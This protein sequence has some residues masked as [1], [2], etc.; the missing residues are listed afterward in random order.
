MRPALGAAHA[1]YRHPADIPP[2]FGDAA[3][4]GAALMIGI[5]RPLRASHLG[6]VSECSGSEL[7][8]PCQSDATRMT[9]C[10]Q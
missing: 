6:L 9:R 7:G 5:G 4:A 1:S 3:A 10:G 2:G 8:A